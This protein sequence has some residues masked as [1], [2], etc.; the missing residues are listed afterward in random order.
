MLQFFLIIYDTDNHFDARNFVFVASQDIDKILLA[1]MRLAETGK[2][3]DGLFNK[4]GGSLNGG[5]KN[6][7]FS[8]LDGLAMSYT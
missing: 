3:S 8:L 4:L 5:D 7:D 2:D 6:E 1:D